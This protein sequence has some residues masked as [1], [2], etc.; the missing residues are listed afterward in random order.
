MSAGTR[1]V[2]YPSPGG[3]YGFTDI[4]QFPVVMRAAPSWNVGVSYN[5]AVSSYSVLGVDPMTANYFIISST[6]TN[7]ATYYTWTANAEL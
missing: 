1:Y 4:V 3:T 2:I 7:I 6:S 5:Y